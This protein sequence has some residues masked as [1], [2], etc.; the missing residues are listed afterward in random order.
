MV[1]KALVHL[2]PSHVDLPGALSLAN[3]I[4][5]LLLPRGPRLPQS[6]WFDAACDAIINGEDDETR[7]LVRA[8]LGPSVADAVRVLGQA[9]K[10]A[11]SYEDPAP[12][13]WLV[14]VLAIASQASS[15]LSH[16][17]GVLTAA[18]GI[19]PEERRMNSLEVERVAYV[20]QAQ[21]KSRVRRVQRL[22][23][24][25]LMNHLM[26]MATPAFSLVPAFERDGRG[27][28]HLLT[29]LDECTE[30]AA[31]QCLALRALLWRTDPMA[32]A[33]QS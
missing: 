16:A 29:I 18:R 13:V 7:M 22:A 19:P 14:D 10:L 2:P 27:N 31:L 24:R 3:T 25:V 1:D 4:H 11:V 26:Q 8:E 17:F 20:F 30:A 23:A 6:E 12:P 32:W 21:T 28:G 5:E 9:T 33:V 15:L